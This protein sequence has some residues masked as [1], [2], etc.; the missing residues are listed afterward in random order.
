[1]TSDTWFRAFIDA[2]VLAAPLTRTLL[3]LC[4]THP[5]GR[6]APRWSL[7][8]ECEAERHLRPGQTSLTR[9]RARFDWADHVIVA[10]AD[11]ASAMDFADTDADDRHVLAAAAQA[12]ITVVVSR[13]VSDFGRTDLEARNMAVVHPDL[14]LTAVVDE[15]VYREVLDQISLGRSR[16]PRSA[17]SIHSA[18]ARQHPLFFDKM[19]AVFPDV[20][21]DGTVHGPPGE[22]IRGAKGVGAV[23]RAALREWSN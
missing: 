15:S 23:F 8:V 3:I 2:D 10:A 21:P 22:M 14:F 17:G 19:A 5:R 7:A 1:M 6:F 12:G 9:L 11:P 16:E 4:G 18:I 13:N 20:E